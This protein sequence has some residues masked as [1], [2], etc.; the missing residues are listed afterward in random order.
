[1][2]TEASRDARRTN[3]LENLA[4]DIRFGARMLRKNPG[5]TFFAVAVLAIGIAAN[6][7]IFS[8]ADAVLLRPLPYRDANRLVI[9]WED[10]SAFG[11][12]NA[13]PAP[14]NFTDWRPRNQVF[15]DMAATSFGGS[16]ALT[17]QGNP[18]KLGARAVTANLF[19]VLGVSPA[20]GRDF[21]PED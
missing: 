7:A 21:R 15:T 14:G 10:A 12:P 6:S 3:F 13:T 5:F 2:F 16:V 1:K 8:V 11:S 18:E 17:G 9:V 19:S 20:R 4:Q